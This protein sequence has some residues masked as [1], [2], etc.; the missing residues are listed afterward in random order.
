MEGKTSVTP[1]ND[2]VW[3]EHITVLPRNEEKASLSQT[4]VTSWAGFLAYHK[5]L[6]NYFFSS[7]FPS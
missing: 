1:G 3:Q 2:T 5:Y 6:S 7:W 4:G